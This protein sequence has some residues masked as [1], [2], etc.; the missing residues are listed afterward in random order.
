MKKLFCLLL[1]AIMSLSAFAF[2]ENSIYT[3]EGFSFEYPATWTPVDEATAK[4]SGLDVAFMLSDAA[5][6]INVAHQDIGMALTTEMFESL[7]LPTV[8]AQLKNTYTGYTEVEKE[9]PVTYGD[10]TYAVI[11]FTIKVY[12]VDVYMEMYYTMVDTSMYVFT[13][14]YLQ[15]DNEYAPELEIALSTFA[16]Q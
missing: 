12:G 1:V 3:G 15:A 5:S 16:V 2:A 7:V 6:N 13:G 9:S 11:A 8:V 14:T 10:N 4:A